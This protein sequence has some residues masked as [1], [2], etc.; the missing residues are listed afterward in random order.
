MNPQILLPQ[1]R[2]TRTILLIRGTKVILDS[3]LAALYGVP[4]K[5]LNQAVKRNP[6]RFPADFAFRLTKEETQEVVT[7][8][9]HLAQLKFSHVEPLAFSEHGVVAAAFSLNSP[10]AIQ[11]STAVVRA[12]VQLR[13]LAES[14]QELARKV[15]ELEKRF[16]SQFHAVFQAIQGLMEDSHSHGPSATIRTRPRE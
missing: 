12:F 14:H 16:D 3:D 10:M 13:Q 4:T 5:A 7:N 2:I 15:K 11:V 6:E 1:E 9:D 8:C